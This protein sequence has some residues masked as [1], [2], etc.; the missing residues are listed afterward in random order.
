MW[1]SLAEDAIR[2]ERRWDGDRLHPGEYFIS[3]DEKIQLRPDRDSHLEPRRNA[4]I[5]SRFA[6]LDEVEQRVP[7]FQTE[8]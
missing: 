8:F 5:L 7:G 1:R 2:P 6:S 3:V 4:L